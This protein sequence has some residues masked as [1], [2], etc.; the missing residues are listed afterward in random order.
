MMMPG[1]ALITGAS[2]GLGAAF[3]AELSARGQTVLNLDRAPSGNVETILCDLADR[4]ALDIVL[5]ELTARAPFSVIVLNAGASAT[6]PFEALPVEAMLRLIRLNAEAP[7]VLAAAL[8]RAGAIAPGGSIIFVSSLS[9]FTGYPGAAAYAASKDALAIFAASIRKT[10]KA[11]GVSVTVAFPGPLGTDHAA[12][13]AP[14]G[15]DAA[16]RMDPAA[17]ARRILSDAEKRR[18]TSIPGAANKA[19]ALAG[20]LAPGTLT[21]LMRRVI[22]EKLDRK[23]W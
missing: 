3:A 23:A 16:R 9:H 12:R 15:A 6:G 22:Y 11:K 4:A 2:A 18:R 10:A 20:R 1:M 5:P 14:A 8:L 13:H 17:A 19:A 21:A 7:M